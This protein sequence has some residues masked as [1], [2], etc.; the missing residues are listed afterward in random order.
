MF[1]T[2]SIKNK[3]IIWD[4]ILFSLNQIPVP[5]QDV[6]D[7]NDDNSSILFK[8]NYSNYNFTTLIYTFYSNDIVIL[9]RRA[10]YQSQGTA[11]HVNYCVSDHPTM[12]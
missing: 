4:D 2:I 11:S 1:Q 10:I 7:K 3:D 9:I 12:Y 5:F 6:D 8:M